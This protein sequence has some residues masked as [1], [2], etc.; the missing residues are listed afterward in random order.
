[1]GPADNDEDRS[2]IAAPQQPPHPAGI[3]KEPRSEERRRAL[4]RMVEIAEEAGMYERTA[5]PKRTR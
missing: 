5:L 2:D 3:D 4:D 1:M